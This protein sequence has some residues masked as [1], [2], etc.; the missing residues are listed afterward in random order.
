MLFALF[1]QLTEIGFFFA[2][3]ETFKPC[4]V[5]ESSAKIPLLFTLLPPKVNQDV[6]K[7]S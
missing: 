2:R 3:D 7:D 5:L 6:E 1:L 4:I